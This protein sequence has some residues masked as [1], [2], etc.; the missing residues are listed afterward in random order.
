[1]TFIK[2]RQ[3]YVILFYCSFSE[4]NMKQMLLKL[5]SHK[6]MKPQKLFFFFFFAMEQTIV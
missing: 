6:V 5:K 2:Q 3:G 1:L 4:D